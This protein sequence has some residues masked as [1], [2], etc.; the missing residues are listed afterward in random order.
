MSR[1]VESLRASLDPSDR[2]LL[3]RLSATRDR[4]A[5]L[6][7][8]GPAAGKRA[9]HDAEIARLEKEQGELEASISSR[10]AA[11]RAEVRPISLNVI[12]RE[13]PSDAALIEIALYRPIRFEGDPHRGPVRA[14]ALRRVC[15]SSRIAPAYGGPR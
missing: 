6:V 4:L 9:E 7:L 1:G 14:T 8:G 15:H 12:E 13:I 11:F 2:A 3:D 10:S 5:A